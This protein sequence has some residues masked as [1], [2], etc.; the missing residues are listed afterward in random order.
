MHIGF[1]SPKHLKK[2]YYKFVYRMNILL[3]NRNTKLFFK[4]K[5]VLIYLTFQ[6]LI[7][8]EPLNL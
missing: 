5:E 6:L 1:D 7:L 8:S 3:Y 2:G 4:K